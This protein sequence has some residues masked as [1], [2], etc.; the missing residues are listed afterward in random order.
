MG[1]KGNIE[2][3]LIYHRN[4]KRINDTHAKHNLN[5]EETTKLKKEE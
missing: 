5:T 4:E 3:N 1:K 2:R